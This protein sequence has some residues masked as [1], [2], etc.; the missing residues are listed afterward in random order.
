MQVN[1]KPLLLSLFVL[2][3]L[4]APE[5]SPVTDFR[6]ARC[7]QYDEGSCVCLF[8]WMR[9]WCFLLILEG[10]KGVRCLIY[11]C[12]VCVALWLFVWMHTQYVLR[13]E[14]ERERLD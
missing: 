5:F 10:Q 2:G 7:R 3:R 8:V 11:V 6:E 12:G 9:M 4:V 14:R 13:R 1:E